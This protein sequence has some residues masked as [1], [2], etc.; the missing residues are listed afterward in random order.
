M[1]RLKVTVPCSASSVKVRSSAWARSGSVCLVAEIAASSRLTGSAA[2]GCRT[3]AWVAVDMLRDSIGSGGRALVRVTGDILELARKLFEFVTV[4]EHAFKQRL[5]PGGAVGLGEEV[6]E[7]IAA[8]KQRLESGD[9]GH[10]RG[11]LEILHPGEAQ[12]H[13]DFAAVVLQGVLHAQLEARRHARH[14]VVE[15]VAI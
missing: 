13:R 15:V 3:E 4:L 12:G 7:L 10:N 8:I 9:L 14:H 2:A 6:A 11:R 5:E 1:L